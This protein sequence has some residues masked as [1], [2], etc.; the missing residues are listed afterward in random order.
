MVEERT[1]R[2]NVAGRQVRGLGSRW[3]CGE[4][5]PSEL[6]TAGGQWALPK[7]K[8][9]WWWWKR[10]KEVDIQCDGGWTRVLTGPS[11]LPVTLLLAQ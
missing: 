6:W 10:K 1:T 4:M 9:C 2:Y 11:F 3:R 8:E 5:T 7:E